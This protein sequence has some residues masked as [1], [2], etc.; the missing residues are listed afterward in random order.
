MEIWTLQFGQLNPVKLL[1]NPAIQNVI[2]TGPTNFC[3]NLQLLPGCG[4]VGVYKGI[5]FTK[6]VHVCYFYHHTV[7]NLHSNFFS[8]VMT[9]CLCDKSTDLGFIWVSCA[10]K[11]K[12]STLLAMASAYTHSLGCNRGFNL[13]V[14]E[15]EMVSFVNQD[16][17]IYRIIFSWKWSMMTATPNIHVIVET[18]IW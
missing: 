18:P 11:L 15:P 5:L 7:N 16:Y 9:C 13:T 10:C 2:P 4:D 1:L 17:H 3:E 6:Q 14:K 8:A 12:V